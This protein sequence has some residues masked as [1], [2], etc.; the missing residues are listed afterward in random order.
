ML[1]ETSILLA[2][3]NEADVSLIRRAL[4]QFRLINRLL[5][6]SDGAE[7]I[8]YLKG[9]GKFG[10]RSQFPIPGLLIAN[11]EL[12]RIDGLE[13][14]RW[15]H[16]QAHLSSIRILALSASA[17]ML[18]IKAAYQTGA[19]SYLPKPLRIDKFI[20]T[21]MAM[22]GYWLW[23]SNSIDY[24]RASGPTLDPTAHAKSVERCPTEANNS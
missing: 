14:I 8:A 20:D 9:E 5:V 15:L 6:V 22:N 24:L 16:E 11:L 10:N 19:H 2:E 3:D 17:D 13:L 7:A 4:A 18:D 23:T 21:V 1:E 12:P